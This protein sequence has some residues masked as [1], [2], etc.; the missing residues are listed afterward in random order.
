MTAPKMSS[1]KVSSARW[2]SVARISA[3]TSTGGLQALARVH[4]HHAG[5]VDE[6]VGQ[7]RRVLQVGQAAA[8]EAL[9]RGHGVGRILGLVGARLVADLAAAA[10]RGSAPPTAAARGP[11]HRA[12][13]RPRR[14]APRPPAN[15]W[16]PGRCPRRC[17]AG[18][19]RGPG[20]V[21]KSAAAPCQRKQ[22][23]DSRASRRCSTSW[24]KRA[25]NI[26]AR[27]LLGGGRGVVALVEQVLQPAQQ[28]ALLRRHLRV[29]RLHR[30]A[31]ARLVQ[32]LAPCHLLHQ[33]LAR[34]R[35]V[36]L[37]IDR[38]AAPLAQVGGALQRVL[39]ALVGLV[40]AHRPLHRD[41][42]RGRALGGEAVGVHLGLQLAPAPVELRPHRAQ[43]A[44]AGRTA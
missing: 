18:A 12:G 25:T 40:H 37:G 14:G 42:L 5:L 13:I 39:Q 24:R 36:A 9:G 43:S 41:A 28:R 6:A 4:R 20:R 10:R 15:G 29:Q 35:G 32:R 34:H 22:A 7:L 1:S 17:A 23:H 8:H 44:R 16:C 11:A 19:G 33:E 30:R 38:R 31:V 21:R 3:D 27:T 2:R 26:S